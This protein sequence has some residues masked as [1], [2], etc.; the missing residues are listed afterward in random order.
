M[1]INFSRQNR[2]EFPYMGVRENNSSAAL[3][4]VV[5]QSTLGRKNEKK[6]QNDMFLLNYQQKRLIEVV[7]FFI[8]LNIIYHDYL[9]NSKLVAIKKYFYYYG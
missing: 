2:L 5:L 1:Y 9:E 3:A 7:N 8:W 6:I 4:Q